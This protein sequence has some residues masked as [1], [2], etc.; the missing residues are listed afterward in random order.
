MINLNPKF[1]PKTKLLFISKKRYIILYG[2]RGSSKSWTIAAFLIFKALEKRTRI[3]CT[4]EVQVSVKDSVYKLLKDTIERYGLEAY[5][6]LTLNSITCANGSEFIF[7]GLWNNEQNIKSTEGIN[8][9]WVEEAQSISKA[10]M[11]TLTP[12]IR[13]TGLQLSQLIF[14]YNPTNNS[15]TIHK[16][17]TIPTLLGKR[18]DCEL[19][20]INHS[21]NPYF[22]LELKSEMEY[23]RQNDYNMYLHVWEGQCV[24]HSDAQIFNG[25]FEVAD[26]ETHDK[27]EFMFGQ[28]FGAGPDP[29]SLIRGYVYDDC[30]W[31]DQENYGFKVDIEEYDK[32]NDMVP[33]SRKHKII[34]DNARPESIRYLRN[35]GFFIV[36]AKK[37]ANSVIEGIQRIRKFKKVI[38]H[39]RCK[40][41]ADEF[42]YYQYKTDKR[43]GEISGIPEDKNNHCID[44]IRY[45]TE[46]LILGKRKKPSIRQV[47]I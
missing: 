20:E 23:D 30:L 28:D 9:C 40:H 31:I 44:A 47:S 8:Y 19:I 2:G 36:P 15:D 18:N 16:D 25:K 5:F 43:T 45:M 32:F 41:T 3:L 6:K 46:D 1:P 11:L 17:Y 34:A 12:T 33:E 7:K 42:R 22:P 24:V 39:G 14:S 21:D 35:K 29:M 4:R 37:G 13:K 27:V 26:F 10:S 38:I